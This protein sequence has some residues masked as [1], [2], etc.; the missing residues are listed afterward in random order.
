MQCANV[1]PNVRFE[2]VVKTHCNILY[3]NCTYDP[4]EKITS[5]LRP[6]TDKK[7][8]DLT[9][10]SVWLNSIYPKFLCSNFKTNFSNNQV[11]TNTMSSIVQRKRLRMRRTYLP[12]TMKYPTWYDNRKISVRDHK[13]I[14]LKHYDLRQKERRINILMLLRKKTLQPIPPPS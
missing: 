12:F 7:I 3:T 5:Q 10:Q 2:Y 1:V 4:H 8:R 9:L 13:L 14:R 11:F 6:G